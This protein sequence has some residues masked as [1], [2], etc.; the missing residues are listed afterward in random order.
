M[1]THAR[2]KYRVFH[3]KENVISFFLYLEAEETSWTECNQKTVF[4]V[5]V[6][7]LLW[8]NSFITVLICNKLSANQSEWLVPSRLLFSSANRV[9]QPNWPHSD[10]Y[11]VWRKHLHEVHGIKLNLHFFTICSYCWFIY[12]VELPELPLKGNR[13]SEVIC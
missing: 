9:R 2:G 1:C 8:S 12:V 11:T 6:Q 13:H 5:N 10:F 7:S 3:D 4:I